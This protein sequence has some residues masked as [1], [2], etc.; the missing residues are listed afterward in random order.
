MEITATG[1]SFPF[2]NDAGKLTHKVNAKYGTKAGGAQ[3]LREM[4]IEYFAAGDPTQVVQRVVASDALWDE[5]KGTL[6][7]EGAITVET[8]ENRITGEGFFFEMARSQLEIHRNFTMANREV[9]LSSDRATVDLVLERDGDESTDVKL[10]DIK[11]CEALGNLRVKVL[12][13]ATQKYDSD[14]AHSDRAV[15]DGATHTVTLPHETE[16]FKG[17]RKTGRTSHMVYKLDQDKRP[18]LKLKKD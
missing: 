18:A 4:E 11:S 10:R 13:T 7:G 6:K 17:G 14:E 15:Y 5:K 8:G 12:P 2:F 1:L 9:L 16:L 3:Q